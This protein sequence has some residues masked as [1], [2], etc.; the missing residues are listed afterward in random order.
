MVASSGATSI[1]D[2]LVQEWVTALPRTNRTALAGATGFLRYAWRELEAVVGGDGA[3][4]EFALDTWHVRRF[5]VPVTVGHYRLSFAGS[6]GLGCGPR[7][8]SGRARASSVGC[9]SAPST[10]T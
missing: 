4:G 5:G 10:G 6:P 8:K 1:L 9:P 7:W 3:E 2:R